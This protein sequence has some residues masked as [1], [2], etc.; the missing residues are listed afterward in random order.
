M[1]GFDDY[2]AAP[3]QQQGQSFDSYLGAAAAPAPSQTPAPQASQPG[4]LASL[5][6]GLGHGFGETMLGAQQLL[7]RGLAAIAPAGSPMAVVGAPWLTQDAEKG[8][9]NL[10]SQYNPYSAA[11]P[12]VAGA[13]NIGGQ[14]AATAPLAFAAPEIGGMGLL[15]KIGTGAALG[16]ANG[17]VAPVANPGNDFWQQKL[18]QIG[19]NAAVG[20]V[21]TPLMAGIGSAVG[22]VT[23]AAR[24]RLAQAGVTMTPGQ[25]L[26]GAWQATENKLTSVPVLGDMIRNAQQRAVQS[27]NRSAYNGALAPIGGQLPADIGAGSDGVAY[28]R[29]QIGN[30]Y[31]SLAPRASFVPDQNFAADLAGIRANLAQNAPGT[32]QQFDNI[33]DNQITQKAAASNGVLS[34]QQWN[35]SRSAIGGIARSRISGNSTPDDRNL[36]E[37]L[38]DLTDALNSGVG[39]SSPP[40]I[41]PTLQRANAAYAQYKQIERAAGS[42]GASN[43][44]N[45][46]TAAQFANGV[47]NGA[48]AFQRATNSGLNGGLAADATGVLG[49]TY[50]DSGTVG[51]SLLTLGLGALAGHSVAPGAV[52]PG[53]IGI[54]AASLPYT[55]LGQRMAQG[56]LMNRPAF[57]Q[58]VANAITNGAAPL[59]PGLLGAFAH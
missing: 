35:D 16:A 56:L 36:A 48:T 28:V 26:G 5:G 29:N 4:M 10:N 45:V 18:G 49:N 24:Q 13:G 22:G 19:S 17:A 43:N 11:H 44:G 53:A 47:R 21:A 3:V 55:A 14:A 33:V 37:A 1:S 52:I 59:L 23:D 32:L 6:A 42:V 25:L 51:R 30:V 34:G 38:G 50:P 39:R 20:G 15:G 31:N 54:G 46:F 9:A 58:P 7:G 8:I 41:L 2:L 40:D 27:F 12:V 57:A